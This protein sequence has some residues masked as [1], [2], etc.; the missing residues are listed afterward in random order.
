MK[1]VITIHG[2]RWKVQK[3]WQNEFG[4]FVKH[5]NPDMKVFHYRYSKILGIWSWFIRNGW[6]RQRYV[7]GFVRFL[8]KIRK[9]Y[10]GADISIV[11]HSFGGYL[12]EQAVYKIIDGNFEE[13][14]QAKLFESL[15]FL[16][17]PISA[18]IENTNFW[19]FL[20]AGYIGRIHA[21][22]SHND[23][24]IGKIAIPPFG[25][26]GYWGFIRAAVPSDRESPAFKP[27]PTL[28]L[29]NYPTKLRHGGPIA[30]LHLYGDAL[31]KQ[32]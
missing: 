18:H 17:C 27:Y 13:G 8:K 9:Q 11:A 14:V 28:E 22:S 21:W 3:D 23:M 1:I 4:Q 7:N 15:V 2:I 16:H 24:V 19:N 26:N 31:L 30:A 12:T 5:H 10:P 20:E 32:I 29:Y 25:H 6:F